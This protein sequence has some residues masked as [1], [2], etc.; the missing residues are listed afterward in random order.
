MFDSNEILFGMTNNVLDCCI[1]L[2]KYV[3]FYTDMILVIVKR[4]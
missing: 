2:E 1:R 3:K 4:L